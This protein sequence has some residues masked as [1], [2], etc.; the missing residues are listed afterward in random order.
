[1]DCL[2]SGSMLGLVVTSKKAYATGCVTQVA[3]SRILE[4]DHCWPITLKETQTQVWFNLVGSLGP[5]AH[6]VLFGPSEHLWWVSG[7]ILNVILPL[8]PSCWNFSFALGHEVSFFGGIQHS[9]VDDCSKMSCNFGVLTGEDEWISI[10]SAIWL[11][12]TLASTFYESVNSNGLECINLIQMNIISTI[13]GKN[14][15]EEMK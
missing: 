1:M 9:T 5:G 4:A 7:F 14:P 11:G 3:E 10:Y 6:Q 13:V 2:L 15:L 12:G 8:L